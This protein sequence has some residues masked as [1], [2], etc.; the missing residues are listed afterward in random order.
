[1]HNY[2]FLP[3]FVSHLFDS[4]VDA[5]PPILKYIHSIIGYSCKSEMV[6]GIRFIILISRMNNYEYRHG[7]NEI[8]L[9]VWIHFVHY[10]LIL[11]LNE[12][13]TIEYEP[14]HSTTY[15]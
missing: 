5:E 12:S 10:F 6:N 15:T 13:I 8:I 2:M 9:S 11:F 4:S 1:M 14:K 3:I 7:I